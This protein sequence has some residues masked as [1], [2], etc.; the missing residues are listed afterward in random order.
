M[1]QQVQVQPGRPESPDHFALAAER[2]GAQRPLRNRRLQQ[3][4]SWLANNQV[5]EAEKELGELLARRPDDADAI[6]LMARTAFRRGRQD[7]AIAFFER[8]LELAPDF[9]AARFDYAKLLLQ[10][11]RF[12]AALAEADRLLGADGRNPHFRQLKASILGFIGEN[13][14]SLA[15]WKDLTTENPGRADCWLSY[16]HALRAEG[17]WDESA[18]AYRKAIDARPWFGMAWWGLA[19]MK[20]VRFSDADVATMRE[21]LVR[22]D[23]S[24]DDRACLQFSLGKAYEDQ[25]A[26]DLSFEQYAKANAGMRARIK[27]DPQATTKLI[28][29][30]KALF[31]REFLQSR[32]DSGCKAPDPIFV[33]SLPRSGSTLVEQI[34]SSHS[35][36]EGAGELPDI[37]ALAGRLRDREAAAR[38]TSYPRVLGKLEPADLAKFGEEYLKNTRVRRK[39]D[40]PYFVDKKPYNLQHAGLIQLILPNA[41]I[42]DVRRHPADCGLSMFKHYFSTGRPNLTELGRFYR[43]YVELMAHFDRVLPGRI[44][45][46]IYE[47]LVADPETEIRRLLDYLELPF[48]E[49]CLRFHE[50]KRTVFTPS[51]EQVRR[52]ISGAAVDYWR[53]FEPWLGPLIKSLGSVLTDYPSVPEE[54]R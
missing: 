32:N 36:I 33:L 23:I 17:S 54:L 25:R 34:L 14:Q 27:Y 35:A 40:R 42:V 29:D 7:E 11:S 26:Y 3:I 24:P 15:I 21:H 19:N 50:T 37:Q 49:G 20:T 4:A 1:S 30:S 22:T 10:S 52:P 18:G 9:D 31:T 13:E 47:Q 51:A 28:A 6:N 41:K 45:R 46:V 16:G 43:D 5:A 39:L 38:G 44:H 12:G 48:E 8:C 53:N 2:L